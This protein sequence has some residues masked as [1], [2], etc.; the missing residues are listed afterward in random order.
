MRRF[1]PVL[2]LYRMGKRWCILSG[3][4][5]APEMTLAGTRKYSSIM[6]IALAYM[7]ML[8]AQDTARAQAPGAL[9]PPAA[10]TLPAS[11]PAE[12]PVD[13]ADGPV[14]DVPRPNYLSG[15]FD[16]N[17]MNVGADFAGHD[18]VAVFRAVQDAPELAPRAATESKAQ[19]DARRSEF[20]HGTLFGTV[21][22][23][24][25][26]AFVLDDESTFKPEFHYDT[27]TSV[28]EVNFTGSM[29]RYLMDSS[30]NDNGARGLDGILLRTVVW[31]HEKFLGGAGSRRVNIERTFSDRYGLAF[32]RNGWLF[33]NSADYHRKFSYLQMMEPMV[34]RRQVRDRSKVML[35]C[36]L[37]APWVVSSSYA[38]DPS[39]A[40]PY[41][42]FAGNHLLYVVPEQVWVFSSM[43][44][45][46]FSRVSETSLASDEQRQL[47]EKQAVVV[48]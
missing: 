20:A 7:V 33:R 36:R 16:I 38:H 1:N 4:A 15:S 25:Y 14:Q 45:E 29:E 11:A 44:G 30:F 32:A 12:L 6:V 46:V 35:V 8:R 17:L 48:P 19:L 40:E 10:A 47:R 18:I 41:E 31:H 24:G 43:T 42:I 13:D 3:R 5:S 22:P 39:I 28:L 34:W 23:G 37:A 21:K 2:M 27:D 9:P 26:L